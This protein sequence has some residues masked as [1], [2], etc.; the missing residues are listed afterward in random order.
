MSFIFLQ[1]EADEE[2][3]SLHPPVYEV[4]KVLKVQKPANKKQRNYLFFITLFTTRT[5]ET[6][7][8]VEVNTSTFHTCDER[9]L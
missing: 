6:S 8:L 9:P 1:L 3:C 2:R 4:T 7:L 5:D